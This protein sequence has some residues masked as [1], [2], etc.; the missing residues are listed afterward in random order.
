[1]VEGEGEL[2]VNG[3]ARTISEPGCHPLVEHPHHTAGVLDLR[4]GD[5]LTC[6]MTCFTPGV[7]PD[8]RAPGPP[9]AG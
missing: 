5:G 7:A 4:V 9:A 8:G 1:V 6:H 2:V 3:S